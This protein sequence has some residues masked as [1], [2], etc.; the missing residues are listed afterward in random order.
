ML[1]ETLE[2]MKQRWLDDDIVLALP[3]P[4]RKLDERLIELGNCA[5]E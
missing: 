4:E 3:L 1:L 5:N 2:K